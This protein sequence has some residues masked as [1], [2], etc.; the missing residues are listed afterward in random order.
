MKTSLGA[1][2]GKKYAM[3]GVVGDMDESLRN[4][5]IPTSLGL[6]QSE[7]IKKNYR[8]A[9]PN[10]ATDAGAEKAVNAT[11]LNLFEPGVS[12]QLRSEMVAE[13]ELGIQKFAEGGV[14]SPW[15]LKGIMNTAKGA[16]Q[17]TP[18]QVAKDAAMAEY[19][20]RSA[21]ERAKAAAPVQN[22]QQ[23]P[24]QGIGAYVANTAL[25]N[26][27][28][29]AGLKAG[30]AIRG[31]G[32]GTSDEIPIMASNGEFVIKAKAVKAIGLETLEALN[33]IADKPDEKDSKAEAMREYGD[34][35][36]SPVHEKAEEKVEG[37]KCGGAIRKMA[38]GGLVDLDP[39]VSG[40][41][42]N[43][44]E[45]MAAR[46]AAHQAQLASANTLAANNAGKGTLPV[47]PVAAPVAVDPMAAH[48]AA[49]ASAQAL[50]AAR[51]SGANPTVASEAAGRAS[52]D[53]ALEASKNAGSPSY[54]TQQTPTSQQNAVSANQA[55]SG[56]LRN[57]YGTPAQVDQLAAPQGTPAAAVQPVAPVQ[58]PA[59]ALPTSQPTAP[60]PT[61]TPVPG[62]DIPT[63]AVQ[64]GPKLNGV[65]GVNVGHGATR[66]DVPGKSPLFTNMTDAAGMASNEKLV[67]RGAVTAQNQTAMDNLTA[68]YKA[69]A[70][71]MAQA[72]INAEQNAR[73]SMAADASNKGAMA[74]TEAISNRTADERARWDAELTLSSTLAKKEEKVA[75]QRTL[76]A[77]NQKA[78]AA[79]GNSASMDRT[80]VGDA[81]TRRGQDIT[82][83]GQAVQ[84][85][86]L[87]RTQQIAQDRFGIEQSQEARA[88][89]KDALDA[90]QRDRLQA[91]FD[92]YDKD[93]SEKAAEKV[94]V[95]TNK[96]KA[97]PPD[98][99]GIRKVTAA[100][101]S[102]TEIPYNKHTGEDRG[103]QQAKTTTKAE[104]DK[105]PKGAT[106]T[107]PDGSP[108]IKG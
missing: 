75:A 55:A 63:P 61:A 68:R 100:D 84:A 23:P 104:Y 70:V 30:G 10:T 91:A 81:T 8:A 59:G 9:H 102:V 77:L 71:G 54:F 78:N 5:Q 37:F 27:E 16:L 1:V 66:F 95:L 56:A 82:A 26:R 50:A 90:K 97:A 67:N 31:K 45:G 14:V 7:A 11:K 46:Q 41:G 107:A 4:S 103:S 69:E 48:N 42:P 38:T 39:A 24:A 15:S 21:A 20:A 89:A 98:S 72:Q 93:P 53:N 29:A 44:K 25:Q 22:V 34:G 51:A 87:R 80:M 86:A 58:K 85:G 79:A 94:R 49:L 18:E 65:N 47:A 74:V 60:A 33:A 108:R 12:Q 106:Y 105:L 36:E 13:D 32:T 3:G 76:D 64:A 62:G 6:M 57:V 83:A 17:K 35:S 88:A 28:K 99:W 101:G 96:E 92:A 19:N 2:R 52:Y 73:E 40:Y 43:T